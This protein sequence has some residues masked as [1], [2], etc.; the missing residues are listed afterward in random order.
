MEVVFQRFS[1]I[2]LVSMLFGVWFALL[3]Q[4]THAERAAYA[5]AIGCNASFHPAC[6][7]KRF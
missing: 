3:V 6:E 1:L 7:P 2:C 4:D 5:Q